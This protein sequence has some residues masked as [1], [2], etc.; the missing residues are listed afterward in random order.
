M[1][2]AGRGV[3]TAAE[4]LSVAA[5]RHGRHAQSFPSFGSERMGAPAVAYCRIDSVPIRTHDRVSEVDCLVIRS[6]P[7]C[8]STSSINRERGGAGRCGRHRGESGPPISYEPQR[9]R[10]TMLDQI[11]GSQA[12]GHV[13]ACCRPQVSF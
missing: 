4:M 5:F 9:L 8:T 2:E 10:I 12:I 1:V 13:L 7:A 6:P 11:E 3:A